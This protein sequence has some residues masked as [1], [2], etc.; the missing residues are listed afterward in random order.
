VNTVCDVNCTVTEAQ[1]QAK[2]RAPC[3]SPL[4]QALCGNCV[5]DGNKFYTGPP[6]PSISAC[7]EASSPP[8]QKAV[9]AR[10]I[11]TSDCK[12]AT[13]NNSI[14]WQK[15][16]LAE[17][18]SCVDGLD[19]LRLIIRAITCGSTIVDFTI[20]PSTNGSLVSPDQALAS[21]Q[22]QI[23]Q[24]GSPLRSG[25]LTGA[26]NTTQN[27]TA[28]SQTVDYEYCSDDK[29]RI[30]GQCPA[31]SGQNQTNLAIALGVFAC[32]I[33]AVLLIVFIIRT[34]KKQAANPAPI[35]LAPLDEDGPPGLEPADETGRSPG[36]TS[37][38]AQSDRL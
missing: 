29:W 15:S 1:C 27:M 9:L 2:H 24:P 38:S 19:V 14:N 8:A 33:F 23:T 34:G 17:L 10:M 5:S 30:K 7:T 32:V 20:I 18:A 31:P 21:L 13:G 22:D 36:P 26:V 3:T 4:N 25:V 11:L 35:K 28:T 12:P 6:G 16:F 37:P